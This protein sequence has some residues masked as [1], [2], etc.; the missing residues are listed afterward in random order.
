VTDYLR[1][2]MV[3]GDEAPLE[4]TLTDSAGVPIGLAGAAVTFSMEPVAGSAGAEATG[5]AE[6][7]DESSA[8]GDADYGRV[9]YAWATA[10]VATAGVYRAQFRVEFVDAPP[11]TFPTGYIEIVMLRRVGA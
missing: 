10:D 9:R 7:V 11:V 2:E 1:I 8:P 4:L 5:P 3:Q 6:V